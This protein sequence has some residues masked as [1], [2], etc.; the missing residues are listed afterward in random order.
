MAIIEFPILYAPD[1]L[2]GRPLG[3][4]QIFVGEPDLDPQIPANQK[5]LN[6]VQEDGTIVPVSQPFIVSFGGVPTYNGATVRLDVDGNYSFKMLDKLGVQKYYVENVLSGTPVTNEDLINDLSQSYEFPTVAAYKA[7][8]TA[9]PVG[10]TIVIINRARANYTVI[11]GTGTADEKSIL[12][13]DQVSQSIDLTITD[14]IL[15]DYFGVVLE[16][17]TDDTVTVQD[18]FDY[19]LA[20]TA[21]PKMLSL[22]RR[23]NLT[24]TINTEQTGS[25]TVIKE[26]RFKV[27]GVSEGAGFITSSDITMFSS[28]AFTGV[29][30]TFR[31]INFNNV[32]FIGNNLSATQQFVMEGAQL[33]VQFDNCSFRK[34]KALFADNVNTFSYIFRGCDIQDWK[35]KF[36]ELKFTTAN[37]VSFDNCYFNGNS[38][39]FGAI[40]ISLAQS[41]KCT[42]NTFESMFDTPIRMLG[43]R[44]SAIHGNYFESCAL[45]T[46]TYYVD[47]N[48][49]GTSE[50]AGVSLAGNLFFMT[51]AQD[52]DP[53]FFAVNWTSVTSGASNGNWCSGRLHKIVSAQPNYDL[54]IN[55]DMEST[56]GFVAGRLPIRPDRNFGVLSATVSFATPSAAIDALTADSVTSDQV[57]ATNGS[58]NGIRTTAQISDIANAINTTG[59]IRGLQIW[60]TTSGKALWAAASSAGGPWLDA[61][62]VTVIT[63]S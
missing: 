60:D 26:N 27:I 24:G 33:Q 37:D 12:A 49:A 57:T 61:L 40:D 42:N 31:G 13:S 14:I 36:F 48:A 62:G 56:T 39:D 41:F 10:K 54:A 15:P 4:G 38:N 55:G 52:L 53:A 59:K 63:P 50:L 46:G 18:T 34:I 22:A 43:S 35:G 25:V 2:K 47:L 11:A 8:A 21:N 5:Q 32:S 17:L 23:Y 20:D 58:V 44:A 45:F 6:I 29:Q 1:P 7:F 3:G 30:S 19:C 16:G 28:V 51:A 9:F